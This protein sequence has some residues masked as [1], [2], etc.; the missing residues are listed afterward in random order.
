MQYAELKPVPCVT[1]ED[2]FKLRESQATEILVQVFYTLDK[3]LSEKFSR[4]LNIR[5]LSKLI[6]QSLATCLGLL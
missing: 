2:A 4:L 5:D 1:Y 3:I 6:L